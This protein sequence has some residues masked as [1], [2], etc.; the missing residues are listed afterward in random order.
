MLGTIITVLVGG[1]FALA[2]TFLGSWL[3]NRTALQI[4][5]L[6]HKKNTAER[7]WDAR[8]SAY[9]RILASLKDAKENAD[10]IDYGFNSSDFGTHAYFECDQFRKRSQACDRAWELCRMSFDEN[11]AILSEV[12]A[13]R[14]NDLVKCLAS[15][16]PNMLPPEIASQQAGCFA[17]AHSELLPLAK[18]E[19]QPTTANKRLSPQSHAA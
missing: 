3:N 19:L 6:E 13:A 2:G 14:F 18:R 15:I 7:L 10:A 12:F 11:E 8:K 1:F 16:D 5:E 9:G 4:S 17:N